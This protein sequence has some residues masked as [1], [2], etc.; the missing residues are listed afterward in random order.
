M[1]RMKLITLVCLLLGAST[2]WPQQPTE[3]RPSIAEDNKA[4]TYE[5]T[6]KFMN[7]WLSTNVS[8]I[9]QSSNPERCTV[10]LLQRWGGGRSDEHLVDVSF[11]LA[12]IDPLTISVKDADLSFAG[13]G[14]NVVLRGTEA[15]WFPKQ[16]NGWQKPL[17]LPDIDKVACPDKPKDIKSLDHCI[18]RPVN[19]WNWVLHFGAEESARRYARALMHASILC[20]GT[21]AVSPF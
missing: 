16:D 6:A 13:A 17:N 7:T 12:M 11:D 18:T 21:K 20:G 8:Q 15:I 19:A 9:L 3:W 1:M 5:D 14:N 2:V 4:A 10:R